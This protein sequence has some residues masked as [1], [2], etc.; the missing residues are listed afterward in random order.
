[1]RLEVNDHLLPVSHRAAAGVQALRLLKSE[2]LVGLAITGTLDP[3]LLVSAQGW[4]KRVTTQAIKLCQL[5]D[6][7]TYWFQFSQR[8]DTIAGLTTAFPDDVVTLCTSRGRAVEVGVDVAPL[9]SRE[10]KGH[11]LLEMQPDEEIQQVIVPQLMA[12]VG[13]PVS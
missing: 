8:S 1:L 12:E 2:Q 6:L 9:A 13:D 5:G 3:V 4:A 10:H 7:G 11:L